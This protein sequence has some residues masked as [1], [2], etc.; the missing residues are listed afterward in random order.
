MENALIHAA[1]D[2]DMLSAQITMLYENPGLRERLRQRALADAPGLTWTKA[3]ER[4][5][6]AYGEVA[7]ARSVERA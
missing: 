4:L 1:G 5:V 6:E 7:A 2:E 3:G